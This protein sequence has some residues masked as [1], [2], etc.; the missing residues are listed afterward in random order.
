MTTRKPVKRDAD[1]NA[2]LKAWTKHAQPEVAELQ[3]RIADVCQMVWEVMEE[4]EN[5]GFDPKTTATMIRFVDGRLRRLALLLHPRLIEL[6]EESDAMGVM[7][8]QDLPERMDN[9]ILLKKFQVELKKKYGD[10]ANGW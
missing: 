4:A 2:V 1:N 9:K 10:I 7:L 5:S 3:N 8:K 6:A